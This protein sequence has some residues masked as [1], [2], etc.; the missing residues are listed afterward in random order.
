MT[1]TQHSMVR[2]LHNSGLRIIPAV[3]T[4]GDLRWTFEGRKVTN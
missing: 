2:S 4:M 3:A 1:P